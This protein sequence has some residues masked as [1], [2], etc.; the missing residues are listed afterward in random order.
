MKTLS[1]KKGSLRKELILTLYQKIDYLTN[2]PPNDSLDGHEQIEQLLCKIN[3]IEK[4]ISIPLP[5]RQDKWNGFIQ[6]CA[7][8]GASVEKFDV[9]KVSDEGEYGL[10]ANSQFEKNDILLQI[11][12]KLFLSNES[13][14]LDTKLAQFVQDPLFKHMPN[15]I[16]AFYLMIEYTKL[17]SFWAPY[18]QI[19]PSTYSTILYL[20]HDELVQMKGSPLLEE[21]IKIKRNVARQYAYF[22]MKLD[23]LNSKNKIPLSTFTFE[24]YRW[25]LSTVMTRQNSVPCKS[26]NDKWTLTLIPLWDLCNHR[27]GNLCTDFNTEN[28]SLVFYSMNELKPGD[29]I[30]NY[31][32]DRKNSDFFLHNG[33][34][35]EDHSNDSIR[36]QIG[37]SR[38]DPLYSLKNA[39]CQKIELLPTEFELG[40]NSKPLNRRL[41]AFIRIFLLG[42]EQLEKWIAL[43][44]AQKLYENECNELIYLD[45]KVKQFLL[46]RCTLLLRKYVQVNK[47]L[48]TNVEK[49]VRCEKNILQSYLT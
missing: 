30:F 39:L 49:M 23:T 35:Y 27:N 18:L 7:Q 1:S 24:F 46:M 32:G 34:V 47:Y 21:V 26:D 40:H 6:W 13:A 25:A 20:T 15:L 31:Y 16:L 10:F 17:N 42:K 14:L 3:E 44:E 45:E 38:G 2:N 28:D 33:F 11:P 37:L 36:I 19:L 12:R 8:N 5:Q 29:E 41:L 4:D 9:K 48:N 22:S 43:E